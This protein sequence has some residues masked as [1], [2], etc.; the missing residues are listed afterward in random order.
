MLKVFSAQNGFEVHNLK[1][2]LE[3]RGIECEIRGEHLNAGVGDLPPIECWAELWIVED[4]M[5]EMAERIVA[6]AGEQQGKPWTCPRCEEPVDGEFGQ[7][8]KCQAY[9]PSA[10]I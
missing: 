4:S 1:H 7:C 9:R 5:K 10:D 3:S 6:S 8:W 2:A